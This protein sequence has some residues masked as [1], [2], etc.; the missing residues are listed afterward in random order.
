[1]IRKRGTLPAGLLSLALLVA[2]CGGSETSGED[3]TAAAPSSRKPTQAP[4]TPEA[5]AT[6]PK[7][8]PFP[9]EAARAFILNDAGEQKVPGAVGPAFAVLSPDEGFRGSPVY[10]I[11]FTVGG[12]PVF[13]SHAVNDEPPTPTGSGLYGSLDDF[14]EQATNFPQNSPID[15]GA[16]GAALNAARDCIA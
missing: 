4:P 15:E 16:R 2:A 12:T 13:L 8:E 14:S 10:V 3:D 11:A 5:A 6:K 7:C 1:M 9:A